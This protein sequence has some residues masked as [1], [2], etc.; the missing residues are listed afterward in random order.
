MTTAADI[1]LRAARIVTDVMDGTATAGSAT[2]LTDTANLTQPQAHWDVGTV[3]F[4]SGT[5]AGKAAA[6]GGYAN[7]RLTFASLGAAAVGVGDRYAVMRGAYPLN[8]LLS[9]I[10]QALEMTHVIGEDE[11]LSGDGETLE[12]ALPAGVY[13]IKRVTFKRDEFTYLASNHWREMS[14]KLRF[15]SGYAPVNGDVMRIVY[16]KA[17]D[18]I[19]AHTTVINNEIDT[20]WLT[21]KAAENLLWWALGVYG[22]TAEYKIEERMNRVMTMLKGRAARRDGPDIVMQTAG[23]YI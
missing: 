15:D 7:N 13:D 20:D 8:Q 9:G 2:S 22:S 14:G 19:A 5:H 1:A 17:H 4:L 23:V 12:F 16:R 21:Y 18:A 11:T 6:V 3:F 10:Q